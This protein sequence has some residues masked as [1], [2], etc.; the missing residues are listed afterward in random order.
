MQ[1]PRLGVTKMAIGNIWPS[2]PRYPT[3]RSR[4]V[5]APFSYFTTLVVLMGAYIAG[6][7]FH[8]Y[9]DINRFRYAPA[10]QLR[11]AGLQ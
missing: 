11:R 7:R 1:R 6:R 10:A 2:T 3:C 9:V 4:L 8:D 5:A